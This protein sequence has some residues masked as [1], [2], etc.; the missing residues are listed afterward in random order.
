MK[1]K[2]IQNAGFRK[3]DSIVDI[4][5]ADE[6]NGLVYFTINENNDCSGLLSFMNKYTYGQD[7][8][9]KTFELLTNTID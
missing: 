1:Y 8:F 9:D 7:I 3:K 6:K 5:I 2:L 4:D